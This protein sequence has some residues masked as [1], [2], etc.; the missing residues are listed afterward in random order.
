MRLSADDVL[1]LARAYADCMDISLTT[2]GV[3]SANNDK[4][5]VNLARG[6]TCTVRSLERAAHWFAGHWPKGLPWPEGI[7]RPEPC[8]DRDRAA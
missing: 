3:R 8:S 2:V 7:P 5:F 6:R 4:M 1:S